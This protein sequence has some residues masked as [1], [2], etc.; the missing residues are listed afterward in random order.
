[1]VDYPTQGVPEFNTINETS[2][3]LSSTSSTA[4]LS[5]KGNRLWLRLYNADLSGSSQAFIALGTTA[6]KT[7]GM[8]LARGGELI[9]KGDGIWKGAINAIANTANANNKIFVSEGYVS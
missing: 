6:A 4:V 3:T 2:V 9:L 5:A 7:R 1:M 8:R